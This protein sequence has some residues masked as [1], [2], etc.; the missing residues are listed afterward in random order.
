MISGIFRKA[1]LTQLYVTG[2]ARFWNENTVQCNDVVFCFW[3][4]D[5]GCNTEEKLWQDKRLAINNLAQALNGALSDAVD[6]ANINRQ[7]GWV[8][9]VDPDSIYEGHRFCEE[10]VVEPAPS[11]GN[12]W[13]YQSS[14]AAG[15][16]AEI[17]G[18]TD[19]KPI[20]DEVD[21]STCLSPAEASGDWGELAQCYAAIAFQ[22]N[23]NNTENYDLE[24]W[25]WPNSWVRMFHPK[26]AA[27]SD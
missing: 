25:G 12:I 10:G 1:P 27:V 21:Y 23:P 22:S 16:P 18:P 9:F 24:A 15:D 7:S 13:F 2:Y 20:W 6:R 26:V 17:I 14:G 3:S 19:P 5:T 4:W 8:T 11:N